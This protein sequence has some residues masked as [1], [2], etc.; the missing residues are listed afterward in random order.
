LAVKVLTVN[1]TAGVLYDKYWEL[2][3]AK[4]VTDANPNHPGY[5]HCL[6]LRDSFI[7]DSYHGPH[8]SLVFD[9]LGSNLLSLQGTQPNRA[10]S[11]QVTKRIIRQVLLAVDYLY[12]DCGLVHRGERVSFSSEYTGVHNILDV[13][14]QNSMVSTNISDAT[15]ADYLDK[16]PAAVY[17]TRTEPSLCADP[18][19]TVKS[20]PFPD[21]GLDPTLINIIVKLVDY[22]EGGRSNEDLYGLTPPSHFRREDRRRR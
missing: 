9:V 18:I 1:L 20:Q 16:N 19:T 13:K 10:F 15:I 12:R 21:F 6:A 4:R 11:L 14:P 5:Q 8:M 17:E 3:S 7:C 22:G 2:S